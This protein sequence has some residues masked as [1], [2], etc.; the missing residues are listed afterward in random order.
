MTCPR[1]PRRLRR[2]HLAAGR[3]PFTRHTFA[4]VLHWGRVPEPDRKSFVFPYCHAVAVTVDFGAFVRA[5]R[6]LR[7]AIRVRGW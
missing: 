2:L 6:E 7:A 3:P 1:F 4:A 5:W